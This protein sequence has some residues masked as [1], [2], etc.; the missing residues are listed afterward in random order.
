MFHEC[1]VVGSKEVGGWRDM[2]CDFLLHTAGAEPCSENSKL[3]IQIYD[4]C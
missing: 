1:I 4:R 2:I 3:I